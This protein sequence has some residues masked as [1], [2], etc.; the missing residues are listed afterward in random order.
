MSRVEIDSRIHDLE[1]EPHILVSDIPLMGREC[2][3][4]F[5]DLDS[6]IEPILTLEPTLDFPEL[7]MVPKPIT[8]EPKSTIPPSHNLLLN[9]GIYHNDSVMIFQ[10]WSCKGNNFHDRILDL[11]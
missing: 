1:T 6:T 9:I 3:F 5:F 4:Q 7:V 2:E 10:D 11:A 8:L